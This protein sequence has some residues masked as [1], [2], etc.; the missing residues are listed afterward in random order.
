MRNEISQTLALCRSVSQHIHLHPCAL[1]PQE[2]GIPTVIPQIINAWPK[3][4]PHADMLAESANPEPPVPMGIIP[5]L[6]SQM[7]GVICLEE[8]FV[9]QTPEREVMRP[10]TDLSTCSP[11]ELLSS[12]SVPSDTDAARAE[13][14]VRSGSACFCW[15]ST[16]PPDSLRVKFLQT[17][18]G[19]RF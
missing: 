3:N 8:C 18:W 11:M 15:S 6:P 12:D 17:S 7:W 1:C 9:W 10:Q 13:R 14:W 2:S 5:R 19:L 4:N 16:G